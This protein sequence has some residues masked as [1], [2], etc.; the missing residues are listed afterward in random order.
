MFTYIVARKL[1]FLLSEMELQIR[2]GTRLSQ[3][4]GIGLETEVSVGTRLLKK[5]C[6]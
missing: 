5:F 4:C 1:G 6:R 3:P 2:K